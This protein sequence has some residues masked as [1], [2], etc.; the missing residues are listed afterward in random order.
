M[1]FNFRGRKIAKEEYEANLKVLQAYN[2]HD[3]HRGIVTLSNRKQALVSI[4]QQKKDNM[5]YMSKK[6]SDMVFLQ[7]S[8][9]AYEDKTHDKTSI[10]T[11]V[12]F[13]PIP[14][15]TPQKDHCKESNYIRPPFPSPLVPY[16]LWIGDIY[17]INVS[18]NHYDICAVLTILL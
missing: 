14:D 16:L 9:N 7:P 13:R 18:F 4:S 12:L 17:H 2:P 15:R 11:K 1:L 10:C 3:H 8:N 6:I 5:K